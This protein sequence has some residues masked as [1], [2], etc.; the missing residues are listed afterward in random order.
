MG[1][2]WDTGPRLPDSGGRYI[3][4]YTERAVFARDNGLCRY[5]MREADG[6]DHVYPWA[7]GGT[8]HPTNLVA[9]CTV[10]NSIAGLRI[11]SEFSKKKRYILERR[12]QL[13]QEEG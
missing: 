7:N 12:R 3:S 8:H 1:A 5:C 11:F 9:C 4:V 10:C 13:R 6:L 2:P